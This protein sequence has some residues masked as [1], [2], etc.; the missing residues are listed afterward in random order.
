MKAAWPL[1][2]LCLGLAGP[3]SADVIQVGPQRPVQRISEAAKL[4]HD[5]DVVEVDAGDY[6]ADVAVWTQKRLTLRGIGGRP[7]LIAARA[8]AEGKGIWVIRGGEIWVEN[9][10]FVGARVADQNGAGIR[11]ESGQ[12]TVRGCLFRDNEMGILTGND[13]HLSLVVEDSEF[14]PNGNGVSINH[15][16]YAGRIGSLKVTGSYFH[17]GKVGH[18]LKTRAEE[19]FIAYNRLTDEAGGEASYELEFPVGGVAVVLGNIIEQSLASQ[20]PKIIAYGAEGYGLT[21]NRLFLVNNTIVNDKPLFGQ[22]LFVKAGGEVKVVAANNLL[23]GGFGLALPTGS[24]DLSNHVIDKSD[25]ANPSA[26]DYRLVRH[27]AVNGKAV[28]LG[29]FDGLSLRPS[30]QYQHPAQFEAIDAALT[31]QPG[32]LQTLAP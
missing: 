3:A 23:L 10:A 31:L 16:L 28:A 18:L 25:L 12:L 2:L 21:N 17:H 8:S 26:Y 7:R 30:A 4:A 13:R 15:N 24:V 20:N 6:P 22:A 27:S 19:N 29:E 5:G 1:A 9:F 32:A 14:G 11:F